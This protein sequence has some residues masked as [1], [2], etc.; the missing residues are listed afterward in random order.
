M[1]KTSFEL[2]ISYLDGWGLGFSGGDGYNRKWIGGLN[3]A[4]KIYQ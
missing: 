2:S 3:S 1:Q 4:A